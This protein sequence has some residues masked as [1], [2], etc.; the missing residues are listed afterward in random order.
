MGRKAVEVLKRAGIDVDQLV[1]LLK[2]AFADEWI[3]S[4]YYYMLA[5]LAKGPASP[6]VVDK[7]EELAQEEQEHQ[8]ELAERIIQLG[9]EPPRSFEELVKIA[10]CPRVE[11]PQDPSDIKAVAKAVVDAEACAIEAYRGILDWL[12]SAGKDPTTFHLIRH[13]LAEEEAHEELFET[14]MGV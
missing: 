13:I 8:R 14:I 10:N 1:E 12:M 11:I 2:K 3:A 6:E 4:Y 9:G 5:Y 7:L